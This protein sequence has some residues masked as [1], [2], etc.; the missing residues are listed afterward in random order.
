M[1][2]TSMGVRGGASTSMGVRG[3]AST[4]MW[5]FYA[6]SSFSFFLR[7]NY[8]MF[9]YSW[10]WQEVGGARTNLHYTHVC[11]CPHSY[12]FTASLQMQGNICGSLSKWFTQVTC[13]CYEFLFLHQ[14]S[15]V[16]VV[17]LGRYALQCFFRQ[18]HQGNS[19][20]IAPSNVHK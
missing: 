12:G 2:S 10:A 9:K 19:A 5:E 8:N 13:L 15:R 6:F 16:G 7:M 14:G 17:H 20:R 4:S 18:H 1:F 11:A 3:G